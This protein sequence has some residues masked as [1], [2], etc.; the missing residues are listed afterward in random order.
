MLLEFIGYFSF[1]NLLLLA[2][3][4]FF[5]NDSIASGTRILSLWLVSVAYTQLILTLFYTHDIEKV[6]FLAYS[7]A[8]VFYMS[9][10]LFYFYILRLTNGKDSLSHMRWFHLVPMI[11][12]LIY[13]GVHNSLSPEDQL[14]SIRTSWCGPLRDEWL[15]IVGIG[16]QFFYIRLSYRS[17]QNLIHKAKLTL[18]N[19][20][21]VEIKWVKFMLTSFLLIGITY[22]S[23]C[24]L[25]HEKRIID[26]ITILSFDLFF[27]LIFVKHLVHPPDYIYFS[28][29]S[30][31]TAETIDPG[32]TTSIRYKGF[33]MSEDEVNDLN[34]R[35]LSI[36][37]NKKPYLNS[38]LSL[39][40]LADILN[41]T[42][43]RLSFVINTT[44][45]MNYFDFINSYRV[46]EAMNLLQTAQEIDSKIIA[47]AF[48]S[49]FNNRTS[50]HLAFK[51]V[52]GLTPKEYREKQSKIE[53]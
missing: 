44:M 4:Y 25:I 11:P 12:G 23:L 43:H 31:L 14:I 49:G 9:M 8:I 34:L 20:D 50:F 15:N 1:F 13:W 18:S 51:K 30:F 47:I 46:K 2:I 26:L 7:E 32:N 3:I 42:T 29:L 21:K 37:V 39:S 10:P 40:G 35:L 45:E 17:I 27:F 6:K 41:T 28:Q 53:V 36:M 24:I 19:V 33:R 5:K 22:I 16:F 52:T 38:E 48:D